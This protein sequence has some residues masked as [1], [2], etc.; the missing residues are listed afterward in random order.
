MVGYHWGALPQGCMRWPIR[1]PIRWPTRWPQCTSLLKMRFWTCFALND[2]ALH[3][4]GLIVPLLPSLSYISLRYSILHN[5]TLYCVAC[6]YEYSD[7]HATGQQAIVLRHNSYCT[8]HSHSGNIWLY[9]AQTAYHDMFHCNTVLL[10]WYTVLC[11][12]MLKWL[13]VD[14]YSMMLSRLYHSWTQTSG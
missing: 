4:M 3:S 9:T 2:I 5:M 7:V 13:V 14:P 6:L 12:C 10:P 11:H 8:D 1:W